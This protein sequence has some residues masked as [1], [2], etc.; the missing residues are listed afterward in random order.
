MRS[1][2]MQGGTSL[3]LLL[4]CLTQGAQ[5]QVQVTPYRPGAGTG[6]AP[7]S[8][9]LQL[10]RPGN[11]ALNYYNLVRPEFEFR[12]DYQSLKQQVNRQEANLDQV[13]EQVIP[14]TGHTTSFLNY[15]HFYPRAGGAGVIRAPGTPPVLTQPR[16]GGPQAP[17]RGG[18]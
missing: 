14:T 15:S 9:Y 1:L 11:P 17:R 13:T 7:V 4:F 12:N 3:A 18:A 8:P 5:A 16:G 10:T 2:A 6:R